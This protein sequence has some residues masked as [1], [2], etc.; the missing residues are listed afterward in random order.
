MTDSMQNLN[1]LPELQSPFDQ[2]QEIDAKGK[3]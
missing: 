1:N 2:L 3:G